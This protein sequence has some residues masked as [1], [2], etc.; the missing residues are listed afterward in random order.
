MKHFPLRKKILILS[1][2]AFACAAGIWVAWNKL[3]QR[4]NS[5][6]FRAS[7]EQDIARN[8]GGAAR[9][10][11]LHVRLG[12]KPGI[13][14][15]DVRLQWPEN[16]VELSASYLRFEVQ[17]LPMLRHQ[18]IFPKVTAIE[19]KLV[20]TLPK[21]KKWSDL[22]KS[23]NAQKGGRLFRIE[24]VWLN[25]AV[26]AVFDKNKSRELIAEGKANFVSKH[27]SVKDRNSFEA[28]GHVR[29][30]DVNSLITLE[31]HFASELELQAT[32]RNPEF[33]ATGRRLPIAIR[34]VIEPSKPV[35]LSVTWDSKKESGDAPLLRVVPKLEASGF[36]R[37]D[38]VEVTTFAGNLLGGDVRGTGYW[39]WPS[40]GKP[41]YLGIE[42]AG[43]SINVEEL[44]GLTVST[45][46]WKGA[47]HFDVAARE[48]PIPPVKGIAV[49]DVIMAMTHAEALKVNINGDASF[50]D[51]S[52][53]KGIVGKL[54]LDPAK[55]VLDT[56]L[57][58]NWNTGGLDVRAAIPRGRSSNA[59]GPVRV[60]MKI[61]GL[62][63][64]Y[65]PQLAKRFQFSK[66]IVNLVFDWRSNSL[67]KDSLNLFSLDSQWGVYGR[68]AEASWR[69]IPIDDLRVQAHWNGREFVV[70]NVAGLVSNGN[71]AGT[72]VFWGWVD[73]A[74]H[75]FAFQANTKDIELGPFM[76]AFSTNP[77]IMSGRFSSHTNLT[78]QIAPYAPD[79][80][81][82]T[83]TVQ[84]R[85]GYFRAGSAMV[86]LFTVLN[87]RTIIESVKGK[88][89]P[90][91]PFDVVSATGVVSGGRVTFQD[92][93]AVKNRSMEA[94][95]NGWVAL[96]IQSGQ[97]YLVVNP[98]V[99]TRNLIS[100]IPGVSNLVLGP[101][102]EFLPLIVDMEIKEG[103]LKTNFRSID[104]VTAPAI[105]VLRNVI[106]LPLKLFGVGKKS[107]R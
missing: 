26:V 10:G 69:E 51:R 34:A 73:N 25:D 75:R 81:I 16:V 85:N 36:V 53:L 90:G 2:L 28:T 72:A 18:F 14:A 65:L 74:F 7:V 45:I 50:H 38:R 79:M 17:L 76:Y 78:G 33:T 66:A 64:Q 31:G 106:N 86:Q 22:R 5:A 105:R 15:E 95:Y 62:D 8:I 60:S 3:D 41:S 61:N 56:Q 49:T 102:G 11:N 59:T 93:F 54:Q 43:K 12:F 89:Q 70:D 104:T 98:L 52:P 40:K 107:D 19:P 1:L 29:T 83:V 47:F 44:L 27:D 87:L 67:K 20:I 84:G 9:I 63:L 35:A 58:V 37:D 99:G 6:A 39:K 100:A 92:P 48:F 94:A 80:L 42:A 68:F 46:P 91:I 82:G 88:L 97:G 21:G 71:F 13:S 57:K 101:N 30:P 32:L 4:V 23:T 77:I 24:G 55:R 96:G 103:K